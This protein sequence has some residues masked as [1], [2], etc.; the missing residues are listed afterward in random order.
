MEKID[1]VILWVDDKDKKWQKE[2]ELYSGKINN[3][4]NS[5]NRFRDWDNLKYWFRG[6]EKYASWVNKIY[7]ITCGH[8]PSWLNTKNKKLKIIKHSD[9]I[10]SKFLPTFNSNVIEISLNRI[11]D[12]S[13]H[14]VAFNDD[15]FIINE[16]KPEDFFRK[17]LPCDEA[18]QNVITSYGKAEQIAHAL[19]NNIDIINRN[20]DKKKVIKSAPFKHYNITYGPR[21]LRT[22]FLIP[23]Y[24]FTGFY[25]PHLPISHLKST[26][27]TVW[28][29]E[30]KILGETLE[31]R[32]REKNDVTHWIFRYWN[33][34][35]NK[36]VP[37]NYKIG[38]YFDISDNNR[39]ICNCIK[40]K[41]YKLICINDS[42]TNFDFEKAKKEINQSFEQKFPEK[43]S[44]EI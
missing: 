3:D 36:F 18:V 39:N 4:T 25:N 7:F 37:R 13:E 27:N 10:D 11:D 38:K 5:K 19:I 16:T 24:T 41:K 43:S 9:Y 29:K 1:F 8:L 44:F 28:K 2:K 34:C 21:L 15:M 12:L 31:N 23:W 35:E 30:G 33:I 20:F 22:I 40:E 32:F 42:S 17:G 6:V 14:F 26:F